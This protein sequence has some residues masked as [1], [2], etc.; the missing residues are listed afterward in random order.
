MNL[1]ITSGK[2]ILHDNGVYHPEM[3]E[4]LKRI[5]DYLISSQLYDWFLHADSR[6]A[7]NEEIAL[8]HHPELI[9]LL[10]QS[11]PEQGVVEV[12][13]DIHL[14]KDSVNA[15]RHAVGAVLDAVDA[16]QTGKAKRVFCNV[17][18][19]GHHAEYNESKGFCLFNNVAVG[20]AYALA[21]YGLKRVAIV[22][23]DVHH[24]NGTEDFVRREP[25]AF[26]ASSF[27]HPLYPFSEPSSD[28]ENMVTMPL[29]K[30]SKSEEFKQAWS[31][32]GLPAL[33]L[34]APELI[35]ISAGFDGHAL[36]PLGNLQLHE[37]DYVW[38]TQE[39][40]KLANKH[41]EGKMISVLEGGY[42]LG[43]LRVSATE[44]IKSLFE[45]GF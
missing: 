24:G 16:V 10:E 1:Y 25:R 18:P 43:A 19:P 44:H 45:L 38:I 28:I 33:D 7:T 23:F 32:K 40:I 15:A 5:Q 2:C 34:F 27:E 6:A 29:I 8:F 20:A 11:T 35:I 22:D 21:K 14:C 3:G 31:E 26:L 12:A 17:R 41:C 30:F 42:D 37:S 4:R 13:E 9:T 39:L 36:D